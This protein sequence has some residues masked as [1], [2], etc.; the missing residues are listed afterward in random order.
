LKNHLK[1]VD[2]RTKG[3]KVAAQD[4]QDSKATTH[5]VPAFSLKYLSSGH[6]CL[7]ACSD[8]HRLAFVESMFR[9]RAITWAQIH[10]LD[11][12]GLGAEEITRKQIRADIPRHLTPDVTILA[13]RFCKLAPMVGYR[14]REIFYVIWFDH[15]FTLYDHGKK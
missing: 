8:A 11:R 4:T 14:V 6:Y 7:S 10:S 3:T 9:R 15:D 1:P 5:E 2:W 13:L 12:H